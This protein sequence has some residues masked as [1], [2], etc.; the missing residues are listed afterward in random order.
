MTFADYNN[1]A[2]HHTQVYSD[3]P[4][5]KAI[6][7]IIQSL[8]FDNV[9]SAVEFVTDPEK[10][11][12]F[13]EKDE[14]QKDTLK[15]PD[16]ILKEILPMEAHESVDELV[17]IVKA[18]LLI[19]ALEKLFGIKISQKGLDDLITEISSL[20]AKTKE[21]VHKIQELVGKI[22]EL[23]EDAEKLVEMISENPV[24]FID[25]QLKGVLPTKTIN[26]FIK[27]TLPA[28]VTSVLS[29]K[30]SQDPAA[31]SQDPAN[32]IDKQLI[33]GIRTE[34]ALLDV[35]TLRAMA[36]KY[37]YARKEYND[38]KDKLEGAKEFFK[39]VLPNKCDKILKVLVLKNEVKLLK[40]EVK[41][42]HKKDF[43][44]ARKEEKKE[45]KKDLK[46]ERPPSVVTIARKS[47]TR[48][49]GSSSTSSNLSTTTIA[50]PV[51]V[52]TEMPAEPENPADADT[53]ASI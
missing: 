40:K 49:G 52:K 27:H 51:P 50:I 32:R 23:M 29:K 38:A 53:I 46:K 22:Q 4:T 5:K 20:I 36:A 10:G 17:P 11:F 8:S 9:K 43:A 24:K 42:E 2:L 12:T 45:V 35:G 19:F 7:K 13:V 6:T 15:S 31:A 3:K 37:H 30:A 25:E 28:L 48:G 21:T 1:H 18:R 41:K 34:L 39:T 26:T 33:E 16:V 14:N 47:V 44:Q